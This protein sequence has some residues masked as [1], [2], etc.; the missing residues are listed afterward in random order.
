MP[1]QD[2][3]EAAQEPPRFP[4]ELPK[5]PSGHT[6]TNQNWTKTLRSHQKCHQDSNN[7][8]QQHHS[9][10]LQYI[11]ILEIRKR[12]LQYTDAEYKA[13]KMSYNDLHYCNAKTTPKNLQCIYSTLC[14]MYS[15]LLIWLGAGGMRAQPINIYI[16]IYIY[17]YVC[18]YMP[19]THHTSTIFLAQGLDKENVECFYIYIYIYT[20]FPLCMHVYIH[21]YICLYV[22]MLSR[23]NLISHL[24]Y[25]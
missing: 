19:S 20:Y 3:P 4:K 2:H 7:K 5:H 9:R 1:T 17:I 11:C 13:I 6:K 12:Y 18:V 15:L 23:V 21:T 16:Y 14:P 25:E 22:W 24:P 10:F 8:R